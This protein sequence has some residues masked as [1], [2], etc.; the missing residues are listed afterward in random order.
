MIDLKV[1]KLHF[2][3]PLHISNNRSDYAISYQTIASDTMYAALTSC[4]S[5]LGED[6][7][8]DG[9]LGFSISS[10]FPFYQKTEG[11]KTSYFFPK[12]MLAKLPT[13]DIENNKKIKKIAWVDSSYFS[14]ILFGKDLQET[15]GK[16]KLINDIQGKYLCGGR[17]PKKDFIQS[18]GI[19][20]VSIEDR[21]MHSEAKPYFVDRIKFE[22]HAGLFFIY[23]GNEEVL[24]K[25][26]SLLSVEGIGTDRNIGNGFFEFEKDT[27]SLDIPA[28][29]DN[30]VN[31]SI[32]FPENKEQVLSFM[33]SANIA[34]ELQRRGGWITSYPFQ[35]LR[36]N[37]L[38]GFKEGSVLKKQTSTLETVGMIVDLRPKYNDNNLH[39]I[40][41]CGRSLILPINI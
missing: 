25:A 9:D 8:K 4:L 19:Q 41:R 32:L 35:T 39:S 1:Y 27:I 12:P 31:L 36:K 30:F 10:L 7:P 2:T 26:L 16:D 18:C 11:E 22:D 21:S 17:L 15:N 3:S 29:A 40:W 14:Q 33:D 28:S 38:Y 13:L 34:Y 20:R 23:Q 24:D 5:K 6:I 37:Y